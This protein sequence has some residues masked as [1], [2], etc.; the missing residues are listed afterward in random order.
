MEVN[1]NGSS[2]ELASGFSLWIASISV[3][4]EDIQYKATQSPIH[5]QLDCCIS[6]AYMY[7]SIFTVCYAD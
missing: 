1:L 5:S 2:V 7:V 6:W 4:Y 3:M